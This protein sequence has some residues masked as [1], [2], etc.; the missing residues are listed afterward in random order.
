MLNS[1]SNY[2]LVRDLYD[3][4][5][6]LLKGLCGLRTTASSHKCLVE[7]MRLKPPLRRQLCLLG[8]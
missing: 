1:K 2:E 7:R 5:K 8:E 3:L 4:V 6:R